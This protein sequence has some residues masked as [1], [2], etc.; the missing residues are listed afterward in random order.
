M[1]L[2]RST[3]DE[4]YRRR[5]DL[6]ATSLQN[7]IEELRR[8]V[9]D[10]QSKAAWV[11]EG[12]K[13]T[14][15][16][17]SEL[18]SA[19]EQLKQDKSQ[20][21]QARALQD[22]KLKKLIAD[23]QERYDQPM[24]TLRQLQ[25]QVHDFGEQWRK[26]RDQAGVSIGQLEELR[27]RQLAIQARMALIEESSEQ[28]KDVLDEI[29]GKFEEQKRVLARSQEVWQIETQRFLRQDVELDHKI[30]EAGKGRLDF[31]AKL[32]WLDEQRKSDRTEVD[33]V[34]S[35]LESLEIS[36]EQATSAVQ[37]IAEQLAIGDNVLQERLEQYRGLLQHELADL[38]E[39]VKSRLD[40]LASAMDAFEDRCR[41][42]DS[43]LDLVPGRFE[44]L[45]KRDEDLTGKLIALDEERVLRRIEQLQKE[46]DEIRSRRV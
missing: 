1:D 38:A 3:A 34:S 33:K 30:E 20:Q 18:V 43:R 28:V 7:Q 29:R 9:K 23:L 12:Q 6:V 22:Q 36:R 11:E 44:E 8:Q 32:Q 25:A 27:Q 19:Y 17:L 41:K 42:L 2:A 24:K 5:Q 14:G 26:D 40:R 15:V 45:K 39:M 16:K 10:A 37:R 46:L 35:R 21:D 4:E 31:A 13:Q